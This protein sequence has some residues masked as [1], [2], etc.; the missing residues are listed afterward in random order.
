MWKFDC[1]LYFWYF[2]NGYNNQYTMEVRG[3]G[4]KRQGASRLYE[5]RCVTNLTNVTRY[6]NRWL[7]QTA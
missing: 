2:G 7:V 4:G 1:G 3:G 5:F 6:L